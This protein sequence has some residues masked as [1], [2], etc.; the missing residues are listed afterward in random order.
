MRGAD[1]EHHPDGRSRDL[2]QRGDVAAMTGRHLQNQVVGVA[3]GAQH[4]PGMT[5]LV[6]EGSGRGDHL[7]QRF[8]HRGHQ[9]LGRGLARRAGDPDDDQSAGHQLRGH[10]LGQFRQR[11]Q[12]GRARSV[13]VVLEHPGQRALVRA[14]LRRHHDGRDT[15]R[16][17]GQ[18]RRRPRRHCRRRM[19]M[20]V[21]TRARQGQKQSP[22]ADRSRIE[23]DGAGD[24]AL[25]GIPR[26]DVG[27]GAADDVGDLGH[28]ELDHGRVCPGPASSPAARAASASASSS[29][30]S[31]GR[32]CPAPR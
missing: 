21:G 5:Q 18:H 17:R 8:E 9:I 3:A 31:N 28:G 6:V 20:P 27:Q 30:S 11:G 15:D 13:G 10:R 7:T 22:R 29:R 4:G 16:P 19:V 26:R 12:D 14:P 1:V 23:L 2:G 25:R 32:T 24:A